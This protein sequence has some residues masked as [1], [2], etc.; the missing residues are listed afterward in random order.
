[1]PADALVKSGRNE[2]VYVQSTSYGAPGH[3]RR[4]VCMA[5]W[6]FGTS[7]KMTA[8]DVACISPR[9]HLPHTPTTSSKPGN[10]P[11]PPRR[12]ADPHHA[13]HSTPY[14]PAPRAW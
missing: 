12:T 8:G 7:P 3:P 1:M 2:P 5:R 4:S 9:Q 13:H 14:F 6:V 11:T 10:L